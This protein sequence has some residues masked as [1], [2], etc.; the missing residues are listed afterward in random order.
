MSL[1]KGSYG[2][3]S[4]LWNASDFV[5]SKGAKEIVNL[6]LQGMIQP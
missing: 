2:I 6:G 5:I 4:S 1:A 3:T